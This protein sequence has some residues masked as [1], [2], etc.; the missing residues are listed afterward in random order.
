M[1][2]DESLLN[3][4]EYF[5]IFG[6]MGMNHLGM[7]RNILGNILV[8]GGKNPL[9]ILRNILGEYTGGCGEESHGNIAVL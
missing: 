1:D 8:E 6:W 4:E 9:A 2:G 7:L 3:I 5:G